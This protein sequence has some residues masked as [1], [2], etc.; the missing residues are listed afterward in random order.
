[1]SSGKELMSWALFGGKE[2]LSSVLLGGTDM[3]IWYCLVTKNGDVGIV[4]WHRNDELKSD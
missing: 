3:A 1:M 2:K 4:W